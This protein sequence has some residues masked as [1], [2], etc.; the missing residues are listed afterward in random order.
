MFG[1]MVISKVLEEI[2]FEVVFIVELFALLSL[3]VGVGLVLVAILDHVLFKLLQTF[4][5][6]TQ[7]DPILQLK[8]HT[9]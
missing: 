6:Q 8:L 2:E 9:F 1:H 7:D 4:Y 3:E 5:L